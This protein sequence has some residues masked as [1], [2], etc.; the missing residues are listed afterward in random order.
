MDLMTDKY[1]ED[2]G[3]FSHLDLYFSEFLSKKEA[4]SD[5]NIKYALA[6]LFFQSRQGHLCVSGKDIFSSLF[7]EDFLMLVKMG[8]SQLKNCKTIIEYKSCYYLHKNWVIESHIIDDINRLQFGVSPFSTNG[9]FKLESEKLLDKKIISKEQFSLFERCL[10]KKLIFLSGGPGSGKTY[11]AS[12]LLEV[13]AKTSTNLKVVITAPTGKAV[14]NLQ[15][16]IADLK[17]DFEYQAKTMH[18]L[19]KLHELQNINFNNSK[20]N[21]DI[22]IIDEASMIDAFL[23]ALFLSAIGDKTTV[24]FMGDQDQLPPVEG[25][26]PFADIVNARKDLCV[27]LNT[28]HRFKNS[29]LVNLLKEGS[30]FEFLN[31]IKLKNIYEESIFDRELNIVHTHIVSLV[32]KH[33]VIHDSQKIDPE[34]TLKTFE[35][36]R[37][38]N[39]VRQ[40]SYGVDAM[41]QELYSFFSKKFSKHNFAYPILITENN[42][43]MKLFNGMTGIIIKENG[44]ENAYFMLDNQLKIFPKLALPSYE[45]GFVISIHKSQGSEYDDVYIIVPN[46]SEKFGKQVLY[47]AIT[48]AKSNV[49]ILG[50]LSVIE[51]TIKSIGAKKSLIGQRLS[52]GRN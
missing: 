52:A 49:K 31:E 4:I 50:P 39:C 26:C 22:I 27:K 51:A 46:G 48:R 19:L 37:L 14:S 40:G 17:L 7:S 23:F 6:F 13:I 45:L 32:E 38:L 35:K 42:F 24:I 33:L 9:D 36:F 41:N 34:S 1:K 16:K 5:V 3:N 43:Q 18:S 29:Y 15:E 10:K 30:P 44:I 21:A 20:I 28:S 2:L 11:T 8:F 47:T 12:R 25:G